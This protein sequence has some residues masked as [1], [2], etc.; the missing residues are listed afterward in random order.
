MTRALRLVPVPEQ[1]CLTFDRA[2][3]WHLLA[4]LPGWTL[5]G[6]VSVSKYLAGI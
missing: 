2:Q 1:A 3:G 6:S 4:P 5:D